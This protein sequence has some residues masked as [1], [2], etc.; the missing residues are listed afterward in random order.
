MIEE[1]KKG[2][3]SVEA[4]RAKVKRLEKAL[5]VARGE[6]AEAENYLSKLERIAKAAEN[7]VVRVEK[8]PFEYPFS[9]YGGGTLEVKTFKEPTYEYMK[10]SCAAALPEYQNLG[11]GQGVRYR[12][13]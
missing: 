4:K 6:L 7:G 2:L 12:V 11:Y 13:L 1:L 5:V 10:V 8:T 3:A 9:F